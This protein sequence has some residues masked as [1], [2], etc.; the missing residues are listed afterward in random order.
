MHTQACGF[1]DDIFAFDKLGAVIVGVSVDDIDSHKQ[2]ADDQSLP[3][4]L[5]ADT[6]KETA[7][8][9]GVKVVLARHWAEGGSGAAELAHAVVDLCEQPN[10]FKFVYADSD[11]LLDKVNAI[12]KKIY[13]AAN[14]VADAK[15]LTQIN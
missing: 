7:Q 14:V 1:R 11:T 5:L 12:A 3:F 8:A 10:Q 6:T 4:T 15:I 9:Y 2:F 13:G